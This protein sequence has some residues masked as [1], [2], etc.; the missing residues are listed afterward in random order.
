MPAQLI[1]L[2]TNDLRMPMAITSAPLFKW[3]VNTTLDDVPEQFRIQVC[4]NNQFH[5]SALV[6]ESDTVVF[7]DF[8]TGVRYRGQ[9]LISSQRYFWRVY[10]PSQEIDG[11]QEAEALL[12]SRT[13]WFETGLLDS[14]DWTAQW[15]SPAIVGKPEPNDDAPIFL[16]GDFN[17]V[18]DAHRARA[19]AT[20]CGWYK[21][22]VNGINI[23]GTSLVP[24]WTPFDTSI[25][26]QAY[27]ITPYLHVGLN[28][29][30]VAIGD[31][32]FRGILGTEGRARYGN[33]LAGLVQ[34]EVD[35][36]NGRHLSWGTNDSWKAFDGKI[37]H[38]DSKTGQYLDDRILDEEWF[39]QDTTGI[40]S[41]SSATRGGGKPVEKVNFPSENLIPEEVERVQEVAQLTCQSVTRSPSGHQIID[42]GQNFAGIA[43]IRLQG[44]PGTRITLSYS[45]V[46]GSNGEIDLN[47][48]LPWPFSKTGLNKPQQD[49][50][51]LSDKI[52]TYRPWF[53]IYGFRYVEVRGVVN[54]LD[55]SAIKGIVLSTD[56]SEH[57]TNLGTQGIFS[58]LEC[59]STLSKSTFLCSDGRLEKL[60]RNVFWSTL[61]NFTDT[62]TD[63]PTRE[64]MGWTGDIQVFFPTSTKFFNVLPFF[65]RF[66]RNL[67]SEQTPEGNVLPFIPSGSSKFSGGASL[68]ARAMS[69]STG[70][71]DASVIIPWNMYWYYG[72]ESILVSQYESMCRWVDSLEKRASQGSSW[73]RRLSGNAGDLEQFILDTGLQWGEWLR[74]GDSVFSS[75]G[76]VFLDSPA[77]PTAYMAHSAELLSNAAKVIG[78]EDDA[79]RY[80]ALSE[81][82]KKAWRVA[83]VKEG[84]RRIAQDCQDDYVRALAFGLLETDQRQAAIDRLVEL[85]VEAKYHLNTGFMSTGL[86]LPT[87]ASNGRVDIAYRL[88]MQ[89]TVPSWLY[90]VDRG[91]TTICETW[92]G[93]H[94]GNAT[95]SQNHYAFGT[96]VQWLQE[97][98]AGITATAPGWKRIKISPCIGGGLS[99]ATASI[100]T[101]L[102]LVSSAWRLNDIK[103]EVTLEVTIPPYVLAEVVLGDEVVQDVRPGSHVFTYEINI[104]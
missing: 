58:P 6:W 54:S 19:Y 25:E 43:E 65:R 74:A 32:R 78:K 100:D 10:V 91:A 81:Q 41:R 9:D 52:L 11:N 21:L 28:S 75:L 42:F 27:D 44:P 34:V 89:E 98:V 49:T 60:Y 90:L 24:R 16:R 101:P 68:F 83:F 95:M 64:R 22:F 50:V 39:G 15:I 33:R 3:R 36:N 103:D 77:I 59:F 13:T 63:C 40:A 20:A 1:D 57:K 69:K 51:I 37:L 2:R 29:L 5:S 4:S 80:L 23:T 67:A 86:L 55:P 104:A 14:S 18:H 70:W 38:S 48:L 82:T 45:E 35:M 61:S 8:Q 79:G 85:V 66:M 88:L 73:R 56:F 26:Y 12:Q 99:H 53:G 47:Y 7:P 76:Q 93:H 46:L 62:A 92:S 97:G 96:V 30:S 94:K 87:L 31:G 17:L 84:G 72:D 71:G 102:G